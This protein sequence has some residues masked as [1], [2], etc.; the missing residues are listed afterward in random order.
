MNNNLE[1]QFNKI[2]NGIFTILSMFGFVNT[3][4]VKQK[5]DNVYILSLKFKLLI[6]IFG[7]YDIKLIFQNLVH[8][9]FSFIE[10]KKICLKTKKIIFLIICVKCIRIIF[11]IL[12]LY[13]VFK[14]LKH[15]TSK[16]WTIWNEWKNIQKTIIF[17]FFAIIIKFNKIIT[18]ITI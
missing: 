6:I 16:N 4:F 13:A 10:T 5:F 2:S 14:K 8:T 11:S 9:F 12:F 3:T 15:F 7:L 18:V 1:F 17:N